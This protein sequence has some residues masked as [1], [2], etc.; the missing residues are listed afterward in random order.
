MDGSRQATGASHT[1]WHALAHTH[2][3]TE[4]THPGSH[5]NKS[6]TVQW[7]IEWMNFNNRS[8]EVSRLRRQFQPIKWMKEKMICFPNVN[9]E[10]VNAIEWNNCQVK[11]WYQGALGKESRSDKCERLSFN[12]V[13][14]NLRATSSMMS[15]RERERER[16]REKK[17]ERGMVQPCGGGGPVDRR[18]GLVWWKKG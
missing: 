4:K 12:E 15:E 5:Q 1:H 3:H 10:A 11:R 18:T 8:I 9:K 6:P 13:L 14:A 7:I 16:E 17:R 2:W